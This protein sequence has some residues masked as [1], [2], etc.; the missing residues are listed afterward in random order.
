MSMSNGSRNLIKIALVVL[1]GAAFA[2]IFFSPLRHHLTVAAARDFVTSTRCPV[3]SLWWAPPALIGAHG[4]RCSLAIPAPVFS[5]FAR[6]FL[7]SKLWVAYAV[8]W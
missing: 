8:C 5:V 1:I 2:G 4:I 6:A 7:R 3:Q